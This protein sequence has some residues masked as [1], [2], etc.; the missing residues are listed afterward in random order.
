MKKALF[1]GRFAPAHKGH[2]Q[3]IINLLND[4]DEVVIGLGSC[5]EV[6]SARHPFLAH[7]REKMI[8]Q[9]LYIDGIDLNRIKI[10]HI[11]DY[12]SF[13][14]WIETISNL[15]R[16]EN[17]DTFVTGNKEDI[18]NVL[19]EKNIEL[20][21]D[22]INPENNS[23]I[24]WHASDLRK[25]ILDADYNKFIEIASE[26][27]KALMCNIG[28]FETIRKSIE[29]K[30]TPFNI[31]RQTVDII[32]TLSVEN[33]RPNGTIFYTDYVLC[34]YRPETKDNFPNVLGVPGDEIKLFE[35]PIE[36]VKRI[37][38][39]KLKIELEILDKIYEPTPILLKFKE[40]K[41]ITTLDFLKLYSSEEVRLSGIF[42]GS[43]QCF[44]IAL[45]GNLESINNSIESCELE[46]LCFRRIDDVI[47]EGLA[48]E[49]TDM[50]ITASLKLKE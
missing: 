28:G 13:E 19:E 12:N 10:K 44:H 4:F 40:N 38:F 46:N 35:S 18:L 39:E 11:P 20:N 26:G 32:I 15:V 9:S 33:K 23:G 36:A 41:I 31:G 50:V 2:I 47:K 48:Y 7:F 25:A 29:N 37:L 3:A 22:F 24:E 6:G 45:S 16:Q 27:T 14:D 42:G 17:I 34:G 21:L 1:I 43:S 5:Y 8:L 30:V 49:Q